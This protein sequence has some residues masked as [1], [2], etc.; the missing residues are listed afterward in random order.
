MYLRAIRRFTNKL[1]CLLDVIKK[2]VYLRPCRVGRIDIVHV[3]GDRIKASGQILGQDWP[4]QTLKLRNQMMVPNGNSCLFVSVVRGTAEAE[5]ACYFYK[6][7]NL[8][9]P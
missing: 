3:H 1:Q 7:R 6:A 5:L 4:S 9:F 8:I 2:R